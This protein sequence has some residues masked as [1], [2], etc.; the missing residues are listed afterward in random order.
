MPNVINSRMLAEYGKRFSSLEGAIFV[1]FEKH[2]VANDRE[3]RRSLRKEK[4]RYSVVK[5]RI[6]KRALEGKLPGTLLRGPVAIA[7]GDVE[8]TIA[9][10]K[11]LE[12]A[13]KA[14]TLPGLE[15]KGGFL[16]GAVLTPEQVR[17]LTSLP[18]KKELLSLLL[19]AAI[20]PATNVANLA[21]SALATPARLV[22]ALID[23]REKAGAA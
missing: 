18:S 5:N 21:Q 22:A 11:I 15:V 16:D 1:R 7:Y 20:A 17:A 14:K 6:A 10:A 13:R 9:A 23:Q 4:V 2:T 8:R 19:S 3:L 12:T